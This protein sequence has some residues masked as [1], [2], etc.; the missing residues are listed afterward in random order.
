MAERQQQRTG[1]RL[2]RG[3]R[4][5]LG[6]D[7]SLMGAAAAQAQQH[8][9]HHPHPPPPCPLQLSPHSSKCPTKV[10]EGCCCSQLV[11]LGGEPGRARGRLKASPRLSGLSASPAP[12][13]TCWRLGL[14]DQCHSLEFRATARGH[15][16][17]PGIVRFPS[18]GCSTLQVSAV[19]RGTHSTGAA[20]P[21]LP[22]AP[23]SRVP[24]VHPD[25]GQGGRNPVCTC[26]LETF[27]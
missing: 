19:P 16:G 5:H 17:F 23:T 14:W 22:P 20:G 6:R 11:S 12:G 10:G 21:P 26:P 25:D 24:L 8:H 15:K 4:R 3:H 13:Q 2:W 27:W 9:C 18:A 7:S 1:A